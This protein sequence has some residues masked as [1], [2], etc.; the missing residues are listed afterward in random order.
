MIPIYMVLAGGAILYLLT[1]KAEAQIPPP[2]LP[3]DIPLTPEEG[4][5]LVVPEPEALPVGTTAWLKYPV[6]TPAGFVT[7]FVKDERSWNGRKSSGAMVI[8][9]SFGSLDSIKANGRFQ[10]TQ[11]TFPPGY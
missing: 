3:E 6:Q 10:V 5:E 7:H 8:G 2:P 1:K 11:I 9:T 4:G